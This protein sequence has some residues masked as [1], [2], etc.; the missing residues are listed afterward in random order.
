MKKIISLVL[1]MVFFIS[2]NCTAFAAD[3][4][5]IPYQN[6]LYNINRN[7][8]LNL[9]YESV[10]TSKVSL[11]EYEQFVTSVAIQQ[12]KL[13]QLILQRELYSLKGLNISVEPRASK[14]ITKDTWQY[15]DAFSISATYDVNGVVI[16]NPRNISINEKKWP[17]VRYTP[18]AGSPT[19]NIIDS[20]R[21][22]TVKYYGTYTAIDVSVSN[23]QLYAEFY[24]DS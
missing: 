23:V 16:S 6:I 1:S 8:G 11:E 24:Y 9:E 19:T 13:Y 7:Y 12:K 21:T 18:N 15:G 17:V 20:G 10:D 3:S 5:E 2:I 22:L 14:T 4:P